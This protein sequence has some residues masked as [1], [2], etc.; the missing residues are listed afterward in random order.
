MFGKIVFS[1]AILLFLTSLFTA[2][3]FI[4]EEKSL[5]GIETFFYTIR[6]ATA[7][8]FGAGSN[9]I[10]SFVALLAVAANFVFIFWA[11]LVFS[12]TKIT[13][14]KWFWWTSMLFLIAA[15]YT[16][17]QAMLRQ[18]VSLASGYYIWLCALVLMLLAPVIARAERKRQLSKT[19]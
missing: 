19:L 10:V 12:S 1:F 17:F 15:S 2:T 3:V 11:M 18:G 8:L 9:K 16:G 4:G 7:G 13:S 14:L 5:T 6:H